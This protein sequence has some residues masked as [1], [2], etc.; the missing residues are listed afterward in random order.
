MNLL[1]KLQQTVHQA[2]SSLVPDTARYLDMVKPA[3]DGRFGDYQVNC[4]MSL[5]KVLGGKPQEIAGRIIQGMDLGDWL[6]TPTVAGPGFINVKLRNDWLAKQLQAMASDARL[7]IAPSTTP[8]VY[9]IDYSS[10]NV[11]KP[12]HVG[13]LRSTIIGDAIAR[14]LRFLGHR[15]IADN[16]LGDWGTQFG[17]LIYGYKHFR[18]DAA[19]AA[20]PVREMLRIYKKV[21]ELMKGDEDAEGGGEVAEAARQETAKLHAGDPENGELWQKFM[22]WCMEEIDQ[23]YKRLDIR[24]DCMHG[25]SFYNPMFDK[26]V[27]DLLATGVAVESQGAIVIPQGEKEPPSIIRKRDGAYTYMTSDLATIGYRVAQW[28]P[29]TLLYVVDFRQSLHFKQL[30]VA[31]RKCGYEK[32]ELEHIKFGMVLGEDGKPKQTRAGDNEE[33]MALL[34]EAVLRA[35]EV[36]EANKQDRGD[37]AAELTDEELKRVYEVVG[38]GAVKYADLCQNRTTDYIFDWDKM[39]AMN[40][41]TA[42]YMQYAY[43]RNRGIFRR[44]GADVEVLRSNP[45]KVFVETAEERSLAIQLLR[46]EEALQ[47]AARDYL[48]SVITAYLW[49]LAKAYSGFFQNCPV[50]KA[51]SPELRASRLLICDLTLRTLQQA[52]E[53]LGIRTVERM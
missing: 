48:P 50:L 2:L 12:M 45:P 51:P 28:N 42:T 40:G 1:T 43:V 30:F 47:Q 11:A 39:M 38:V 36:Y 33:L 9:V 7:G 6:E 3:Q 14:L 27:K 13:H 17:I 34:D 31:A 20:D 15:V 5:G 8:K 53:L 32:I 25:E 29:D 24:F 19:L 46:F 18:D 52:L 4:A 22:P 41:N 37:D 21:R 44:G 10:P 23:V 26:T 16:H 35:R 49:D